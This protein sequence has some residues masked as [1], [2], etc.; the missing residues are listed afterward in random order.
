MAERQFV[1]CSNFMRICNSFKPFGI[2]DAADQAALPMWLLEVVLAAGE[3][4]GV[5]HAF[6]QRSKSCQHHVSSVIT[7]C[8]L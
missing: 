8:P 6:L 5:I 1:I 3:Q 2:D 4:Q 7:W